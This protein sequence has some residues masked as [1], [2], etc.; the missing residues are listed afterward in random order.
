MRQILYASN[1]IP[2]LPYLPY[3]PSFYSHMPRLKTKPMALSRLH[4][5]LSVVHDNVDALIKDIGIGKIDKAAIV[6]FARKHPDALNSSDK[7]TGKTLLHCLLLSQVHDVDL[8]K[9]LLN[10]G[11][12][13]CVRDHRGLTA[14]HL[15]CD[16]YIDPEAIILPFML[17]D[18]NMPEK[19]NTLSIWDI[20]IDTCNPKGIEVICQRGAIVHDPTRVSLKMELIVLQKAPRARETVLAFI[21][22]F[23]KERNWNNS[24]KI[25]PGQT[26]IYDSDMMNIDAINERRTYFYNVRELAKNGH[27]A[28]LY[29]M[30]LYPPKLDKSPISRRSWADTQYLQLY[31]RDA[32]GLFT[33]SVKRLL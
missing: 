24:L 13:P 22:N 12:S 1:T 17:A 20:A 6:A 11:A 27:I 25:V 8:Y 33:K 3:L 21:E 7:D 29:E 2:Y 4:V 10:L 14:A 31:M 5:G 16:Y 30:G 15:A 23:Y 32:L 18:C 26:V 19:H 9:T 28:T